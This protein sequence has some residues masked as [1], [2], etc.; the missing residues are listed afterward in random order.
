MQYK[1]IVLELLKE[2][3]QLHEQL[4]KER[5]LLT[6]LERYARELKTNHE[7]WMD[8]LAQMRPGSSQTQLASE[9]MEM[10]LKELEDR[11]PSA[12]PLEGSEAMVLD[13]AMMFRRRPT[14][15]G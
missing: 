12:S 1:T 15:R 10:A 8:M 11:L 3:T 7:A 6:T 2:R 5:K 14:S 9:A 13:A 4:R